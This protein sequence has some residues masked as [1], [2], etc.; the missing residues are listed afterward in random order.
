VLTESAAS[1]DAKQ[2]ELQRLRTLMRFSVLKRENEQLETTV[3]RADELEAMLVQERRKAREKQYEVERLERQLER[4]LAD[5]RGRRTESSELKRL[6][7]L[8][9][10]CLA[11]MA[12]QDR[13]PQ[14]ALSRGAAGSGVA[15]PQRPTSASTYSTSFLGPSGRPMSAGASSAVITSPRGPTGKA[16]QPLRSLLPGHLLRP[17]TRADGEELAA[18]QPSSPPPPH[19]QRRRKAAPLVR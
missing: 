10:H 9:T 2:R 7:L 11:I 13:D 1:W 3:K 14:F 8:E 6:R 19:R 15:P 12:A 4:A 18:P 5:A 17:P 16:A